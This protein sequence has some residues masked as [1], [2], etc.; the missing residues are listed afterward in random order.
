[1]RVKGRALFDDVKDDWYFL[2]LLYRLSDLFVTANDF[3]YALYVLI[4]CF[5][6][7]T[8]LTLLYADICLLD[9]VDRCLLSIEGA[10]FLYALGD[11]ID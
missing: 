3:V 7:L 9:S 5:K 2:V 11:S 10:A 6:V 1:M 4:L 8:L